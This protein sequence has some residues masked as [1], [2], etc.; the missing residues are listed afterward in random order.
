MKMG[1]YH[2][3]KEGRERKRMMGIEKKRRRERKKGAERK[4]RKNK[5]SKK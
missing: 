1:R 5:V 2:A 4:E 3:A